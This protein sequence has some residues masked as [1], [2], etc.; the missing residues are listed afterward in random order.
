[1]NATCR[2]HGVFA[3]DSIGLESNQVGPGA[4]IPAAGA[5]QSTFIAPARHQGVGRYVVTC[6]EP[7]YSG[8]QSNDSCRSLMAEL[9]T[10]LPV[11]CGNRRATVALRIR[12]HRMHISPAN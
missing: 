11:V 2:N 1:M 9:N 3:K 10:R 5:A 7:T 8:A 6:R 4:R 12:L